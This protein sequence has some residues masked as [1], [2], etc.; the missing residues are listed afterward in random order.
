MLLGEGGH[1]AERM[2]RSKTTFYLSN[3]VL[4]LVD[5][6]QSRYQRKLAV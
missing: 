4:L 1:A 3:T 6:I 5:R 2:P